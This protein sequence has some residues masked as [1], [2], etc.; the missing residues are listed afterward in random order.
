MGGENAIAVRNVSKTFTT[1]ADAGQERGLLRRTGKIARNVINDVSFD[2]RKGEVFGIV[3]RNG[4]GKS[5]L[6]KMISRIMKPDSGS[7]EINGRIA[8]ILELGMGFHQ[9]LS[10]RENIYIKGSM[11]GFTKEQIDGRFDDIV[12]YAELEDYIDLPI[13]VYSSGMSSRLAFAIMIN[14]DADILILDE[15]LS[16]GDLAFSKKSGAHFSNM[17]SQGRTIIIV[18][19]AMATIRSMCDRVAWID[20]GRIREIGPANVVCGHY[21]TEL[22]ESFDVIKE[23]AESGVPASQNTLGC[24]YRDGGKAE[25]DVNLAVRWFEEAI[26]RDDDDAKVNLGDMI[27]SGTISDDRDRA[28]NLYMSAAWNGNRDA[29]SKLSRLLT[30][31]RADVGREVAEDFRKLLPSGNPRLLYEYADLLMK[32]AWNGEDRVEAM[33]WYM[34][35]A[36]SG[37]SDAMYQ[38]SMMYRDGNGPK[39]DDAEHLRWLRMAAEGGHAQSQLMLG[40]MHRDGIKVES[41]DEEAF[42]WYRAAADNNSLEGIYQVAMMCREG[43]GTEKNVEES[44][45]WLKLYSEHSLF[46]QINILADS[47]SHSKN[48]VYN[49]DLGMRWYSVNAGH[50]NPE[51]E[52]QLALLALNEGSSA[53]GNAVPLLES[54]AGRKHFGSANQLLSMNGLGL[55]DDEIS[56]KALCH[57]EDIARSGDVWA[58]NAVGHMFA[59]GRIAKADGEK[60]TTY[61]RMAANGGL[62]ASMQKL[63]L[64]YRDGTLVEQDFEEAIS[65]FRKGTTA[66]N[67]WSAV[68]LANMYGAG[69]AGKDDLDFAVKGLKAMCLTGNV[70]AMRTLGS[71]YRSGTAVEADGGKALEWLTAAARFGDDASK[72]M[73]G[74]MYRDGIGAEEDA[75]EALRWFV[76]AAEQGNVH[77]VLAIIRMRDAG[78]ADDAS[79]AYALKRLEQLADGGNVIAMRSMGNIHLE[80]KVVLKDTEKAK[81]WFEKS[82]VL[83]DVFSRS[84]LKLL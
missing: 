52:Y 43:K 1:R 44:D 45:R 16:T 14:V 35:S 37:N 28:L 57:M 15:V 54:A 77:S 34:R 21:E 80:G 12:K 59:D 72:H 65:W 55:I 68:C 24:I 83:G 46:R 42:R 6:L 69:A 61:L 27:V 2:I 84:K 8:S 36:E 50:N 38:I 70:V 3:G 67:L 64:M 18:S 58:A 32:T 41:N 33:K 26:K 79:F 73:I 7:I 19:H 39:R 30:E 48:G 23:L 81:G 13:R 10:G 31:D 22:A 51:S 82:A 78:R 4:S 40:N 25:K 17:K 47:F 29:R 60:A 9:D 66:G 71:F 74:E 20:G 75:S 49:P 63:G 62:S 11:Y 5:T 56:E 76:S 53:M